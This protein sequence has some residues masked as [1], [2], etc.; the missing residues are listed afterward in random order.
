MLTISET[1]AGI[2]DRFLELMEEAM[3][4]V[5]AQRHNQDPG[6]ARWMETIKE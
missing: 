3:Q 1:E 5:K 4:G 6:L 2:E